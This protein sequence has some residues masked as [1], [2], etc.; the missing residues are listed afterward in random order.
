MYKVSPPDSLVDISSLAETG[1]RCC[2]MSTTG[3]P[4]RQLHS[5]GFAGMS[6]SN[7]QQATFSHI[8]PL[9]HVKW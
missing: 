1:V 6:C 3:L 5:G 7:R 2:V 9:G 8:V 4:L